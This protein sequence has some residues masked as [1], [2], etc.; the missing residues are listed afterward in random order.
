MLKFVRAGVLRAY[1]IGILKYGEEETFGTGPKTA[2][3]INRD[4][5]PA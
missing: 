5:D 3:S 1:K 2:L 4:F